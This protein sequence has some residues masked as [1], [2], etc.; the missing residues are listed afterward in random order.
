MFLTALAGKSRRGKESSLPQL[1]WHLALQLAVSCDP[2]AA[3]REA[4]RWHSALALTPSSFRRA[5]GGDD[6]SIFGIE[7]MYHDKIH[8]CVVCR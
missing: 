8:Q 1:L 3:Q 5:N 2:V 6:R 7:L 4:F